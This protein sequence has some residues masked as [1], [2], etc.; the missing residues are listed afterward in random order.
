MLSARAYSFHHKSK[1]AISLSWIGGYANVVTLLTCGWV[2]SHMTGPTTW[3]GRVIVEGSGPVG[4]TVQTVWFFGWV[5][6]A[7]WL[8][9]V[10]SALMIEGAERRGKASKYVLPLMVEAILLSIFAIAINLNGGRGEISHTPL[11]FVVNGLSCFAM[12]LQNATVT[13]ISG[14]VV[15]TTHVTGVV[16]DL[17]IDAVQ[18][19][20]WFWDQARGRHW[21]RHGRLIKVSQRH[22]AALRLALLASIFGS[23]LFG[24][25]AGTYVYLHAYR[26]AMLLPIAFLGFIVLMDW[27]RPITDVRELD[28]LSDPELQMHGILHSLLPPGLG[29]YRL[30]AHHH[31][32]GN[33]RARA[34]DFQVWA[35]HL[36]SR[37][38]V[39]ILALTSVMRLDDNAL[40]NLE[41]AI[42]RVADEGRQLVLCGVSTQQYKLLERRGLVERVGGP[43]NVCVD[44]EFAIARGIELARAREADV[45]WA[46]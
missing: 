14:A 37:W 10:T 8:G 29:V 11:L 12:G 34:P 43:A 39:V 6:L 22:P 33:R 45:A 17:G 5:I 41:A 28:L 25:V 35:E 44:L 24:A 7:F 26:Q 21:R 20:Y 32:P 42:D 2:S 31:K 3:F 36:P 16:T 1:L 4:A 27:I 9:A 30:A 13:R 38:R 23:F 15:R 46:S 18:Y 40:L 19:L